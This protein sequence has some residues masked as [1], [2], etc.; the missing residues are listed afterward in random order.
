MYDR[1]LEHAP[2]YHSF[3]SARVSGFGAFQ[4]SGEDFAAP[5]RQ[6][7]AASPPS[8]RGAERRRTRPR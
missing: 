2:G 5:L 1:L 3:P 4:R 8:S 6:R 7:C